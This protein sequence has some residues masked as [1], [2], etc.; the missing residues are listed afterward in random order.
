MTERR[1]QPRS[2]DEEIAAQ[3]EKRAQTKPAKK[4][5][6]SAEKKTGMS[7]DTAGDKKKPKETAKRKAAEKSEKK[8]GKKAFEPFDGMEAWEDERIRKRNPFMIDVFCA[9]TLMLAVFMWM[10]LRSFLAGNEDVQVFGM[11]GSWFL[12]GLI[13]LFGKTAL[14]A[15]VFLIVWSI[16]LIWT[17]RLWSKRMTGLLLLALGYT[18]DYSLEKI[19]RG[20]TPWEAAGYGLGGGY[21]GAVL[22]IVGVKFV[23]RIGTKILWLLLLFF[24]A[25]LL[26][27][28]PVEVLWREIREK[29]QPVSKR[30]GS[31]I[32]F[33]EGKKRKKPPTGM[34]A[35]MQPEGSAA[36]W[37]YDMNQSPVP[38]VEWEDT[39]S[40][41]YRE[42]ERWPQINGLERNREE[43]AETDETSFL[44]ED[45]ANGDNLLRIGAE[46]WL[47]KAEPSKPAQPF[48]LNGWG[49][50]QNI[51]PDRPGESQTA[52][53]NSTPEVSD[54]TF[55]LLPEEA[56]PE[57]VPYVRP[58]LELLNHEVKAWN[59]NREA[60][61]EKSR[62]LEQALAEFGVKVQV[63]E[64]TCGPAVT[65][66]EMSLAP[67]TKVSKIVGLS[68]DLQLRLAAS[69]I[70]IEA[71]IPGKS[72]VGIEVPNKEVRGVGLYEILSSETFAAMNHP[73]AFALGEDITGRAICARLKDMPHLLIAGSTGSGKSV[74]LNGIIM[75]LLFH[76]EPDELKMV[77]IDPK[78]VELAVYNDL[79]HL[80]TP[81]VT[82]PKKAAQILAWMTKEMEKRY[83]QF[84]EA[85]V[86]D[87]NRYREVTGERMPY[88]IIIIDELAD[89]MMVSANE[90]ED[91]ICRLA[92]MARAAGMHLIV[93]TQRPS[94]DVV[95]GIIK[96]NIPSR[97]AF[98]VSS[99]MDS[100]TI[101]DM[102]GA[103]K[104]LGKGDMLF[105]PVGA[106]KPQRIQ[107]AFVSDDEIEKTVSFIT[108]QNQNKVQYNT[109]LQ[110]LPAEGTEE[111]MAAGD[112]DEELLREAV[113]V[114]IESKKASASLLQRKLRIG[115]ARAARLMDMMEER[116]IV[117]PPDS[118]SK[119]TVLVRDDFLQ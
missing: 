23:G 114:V 101:L 59:I 26:I 118:G 110:N 103:E 80:M 58:K 90:V 105:L 94:V 46:T 75:S 37:D 89:L 98:A 65:R 6:Q 111:K 25:V 21:V 45:D 41:M 74:C 68:D 84:A 60:I 67:G 10:G 115:F 50:F 49:D 34:M 83:Q 33:D 9:I 4:T 7:K 70:R 106:S 2:L 61:R 18:L 44:A 66:Y 119:R 100:R 22:T 20:L 77:L 104:L 92:Q 107:G 95:T 102:G 87:I 99:Q 3:M 113:R 40:R 55:S 63:E 48:T 81:V 38:P 47:G 52:E 109:E 56:A 15:P 54:D 19:P 57:I 72:A 73:T 78:M 13:A 24:G 108:Q 30:V 11:M 39:D 85:G 14:L 16:H 82:N 64:V 93:A 79:P 88:I 91:S 76:A 71:P 42:E 5:L 17:K 53:E 112:A 35:G 8:T 36:D 69:G 27:Q 29:L 12:K 117:S 96:A 28:R 43:N 116:G 1:T 32:F 86:R 62:A 97:I 51:A 31:V